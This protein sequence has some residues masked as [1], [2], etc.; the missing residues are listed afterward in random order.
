MKQDINKWRETQRKGMLKYQKN[1][2]KKNLEL[3]KKGLL[4][5][6]V[7]YNEMK[8]LGILPIKIR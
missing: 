5:P 3:Q 6:K 1:Q 7:A 2:R 8:R 4:F